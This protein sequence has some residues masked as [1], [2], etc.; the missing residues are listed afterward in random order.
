MVLMKLNDAA[1]ISSKLLSED[2]YSLTLL[3]D[4][5]L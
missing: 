2:D 3:Y 5:M 4:G 1:N